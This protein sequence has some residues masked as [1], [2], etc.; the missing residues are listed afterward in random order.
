MAGTD[1]CDPSRPLPAPAP[2]VPAAS[3]AERLPGKAAAAPVPPSMLRVRHTASTEQAAQS[4]QSTQHSTAQHARSRGSSGTELPGKEGA[5]AGAAA[6]PAPAPPRCS[7]APGLTPPKG[8]VIME[9]H[10]A[11]RGSGLPSCPP[12]AAP[13]HVFLRLLQAF[14]L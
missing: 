1:L 2:A 9:K 3:A 14:Q 8:V 7:G 12:S 10:K 4:T 13:I 11:A 5:A 6:A